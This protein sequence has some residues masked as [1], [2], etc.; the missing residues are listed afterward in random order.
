MQADR[1]RL[2]RVLV[3]IIDNAIRHTPDGGTI[4]LTI[5]ADER[6]FL[7]SVSDTGPG[8][9]PEKK[10]YLFAPFPTGS[11]HTLDKTG[12]GLI[13]CKLAVEAHGGEIGMQSE[14]GNETVFYFT[15][16][17]QLPANIVKVEV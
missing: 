7:F 1:E 4:T 3:N 11:G 9:S 15:I 6:E 8:I 17:R 14:D 12:L 13:F 16:P 2:R 5:H 10:A